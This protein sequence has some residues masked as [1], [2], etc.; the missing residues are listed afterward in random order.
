M[1]LL[2][3]VPIMSRIMAM[4]I[5]PSAASISLAFAATMSVYLG[6]VIRSS[7]SSTTFPSAAKSCKRSSAMAGCMPGSCIS[8]SLINSK[9]ALSSMAVRALSNF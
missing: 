7:E 3:L 6:S 5:L 2:R 8:A 1:A 9:P 4:E